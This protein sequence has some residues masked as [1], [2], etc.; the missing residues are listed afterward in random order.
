MDGGSFDRLTRLLAG[1][2]T[3]RSGAGAAVAGLLGLAGTAGLP[4][5]MPEAAAKRGGGETGAGR[6]PRGEGEVEDEKRPCGPKARDNRC[7]R[8][9]D[10]CTKYCRKPKKGSAAKIGRCRCI[11]VGKKCKDGQKCC[12]GATCQNRTCTP[13][14]V[15]TVCASGCAFTDVNAAYDAAAPGDT[16][17]I[18][19]G[20]YTTGIVVNK[21]ITLAACNDTGEV[22]LQADPVN[23]SPDGYPFIVGEDGESTTPY[24]VTLE[25]LTLRGNGVDTEDCL[26]SSYTVGNVSFVLTGCTARD[27]ESLL[28]VIGGNHVFTGTT[29]EASVFYVW[30]VDF[31][32]T[33][34]GSI[35]ASG[36]QFQSKGIAYYADGNPDPSK[37]AATTATF[38]DCTFSSTDSYA[39]SIDGGSI[40]LTR[41]TI[42]NSGNGGITLGEATVT[43]TDCTITSNTSD[44]Y[45]GIS[46]GSGPYGST[47]TLAGSTLI[48]GNTN[49]SGAGGIRVD[50]QGPGPNT[51]TGSST[52]NVYGNTSPYQCATFDGSVYT[53]KPTCVF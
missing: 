7:K 34:S 28:Y 12:G 1:R 3:R 38:T 52:T 18:A 51:V 42:S 8:N 36:C 49:A 9:K 35:V 26:L 41:C 40:V 16:I 15:C 10:C 20:T 17:L 53:D 43:L 24:T 50:T 19:P 5:A 32:E 33:E 37:R 48:T 27:T 31:V 21:N 13:Q 46:V 25:N 14:V 30:Y 45:G 22:I 11:K 44:S 23:L 39:F 47:L 4:A 29:T 6:A 2:L